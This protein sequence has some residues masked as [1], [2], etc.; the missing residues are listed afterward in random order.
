[1]KKKV[2][3]P[4]LVY[5]QDEVYHYHETIKKIREIE[6]D[7]LHAAPLVDSNGGGRSNLPSD[8]TAKKAAALVDHVSLD[9][10][11]NMIS[12]I[13]Y[14][15]DSLPTEKQ[16]LIHLMYWDRPQIYKWDGAAMQLGC[17]TRT[18]RNWRDDIFTALAIR[19]GYRLD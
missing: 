6:L 16:R 12:A 13:S 3:G 2:P 8:P 1:M 7:I 19:L 11:R 4:L 17:T 10:M 5:L 15:Y 9:R 18:V 14:V